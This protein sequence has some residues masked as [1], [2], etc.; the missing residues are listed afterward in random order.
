MDPKKIQAVVT[1][2]PPWT[3]KEVKP[4]LG[5]N[6]YSRR[7]V[8]DYG[9]IVNPINK[10]LKKDTEFVWTNEC[11]KAFDII[12]QKLTEEPILKYPNFKKTFTLT[13]DASGYDIEAVLSQEYDGK[14]LPIQFLSRSLNS[15]EKNYCTYEKDLT[16]TEC[17][18]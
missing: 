1:L 10:L 4:F 13:T 12:K 3:Q 2:E 8:K 11:Q 6:G 14:D 18:L 5:M 7:F 17:H 16:S 9:K 15:A